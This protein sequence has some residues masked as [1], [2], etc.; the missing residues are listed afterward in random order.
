MVVVNGLH[1]VT[2][3][4]RL[5]PS[6]AAI[7]GPCKVIPQEYQQFT[8]Q[9]L[10]IIVPGEPRL[11][12]AL[13]QQ[14]LS[15]LAIE[16]P[17]P[18]I[19]YRGNHR[20]L[21]SYEKLSLTKNTEF[22]F[23]E[24]GV[25]LI[26]GGLGGVGLTL[27]QHIARQVRTRLVLVGR[28]AFP[29][30]SEW[31]TRLSNHDEDDEVRQQIEKLQVLQALGAEV[32]IARADV[33]S[34]EDMKRVI[35]ETHEK[36]GKIDG[37]IHA[38]GVPPGGMIQLKTASAATSVLDPKIKGTLVLNELLKDEQLELPG[39]VFIAYRHYGRLRPGGSLCR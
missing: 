11:R 24:G 2:G 6:K 19:A 13:T 33:T 29:D 3:E 16:K 8:C 35:N 25:Y 27:A 15:E 14:L 20:W 37:V 5:C 9:A 32:F 28:S 23:R 39:A 7:L 17:E 1:S 4:D 10:D 18:L 30:I 36:F 38:A 12:D 31:A 22:V 34:R 21:R 26:T